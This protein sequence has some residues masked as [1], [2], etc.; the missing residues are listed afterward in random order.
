MPKMSFAAALVDALAI[1]MAEDPTV[2]IIGA[3]PLGLG[4]QRTLMDRVRERFADRIID[5]PIA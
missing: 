5:P 2:S 3:Y 1:A 4:P